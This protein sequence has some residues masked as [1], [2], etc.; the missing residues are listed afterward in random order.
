LDSK[1]ISEQA[2][3]NAI[4]LNTDAGELLAGSA[5]YGEKS[6]DYA[7]GLK[8]QETFAKIAKGTGA[9]VADVAATA[10]IMR[11]QNKNLDEKEMN[12][13]LL[14][15]I[16]Q[17][18]IGSV[19]FSDLG[20]V[21]GNF[22]RSSVSYAGD[23]AKNQGILLG[24][25][26]KFMATAGRDPREA[27]TVTTNLASDTL[28][29]ADAISD[30]VGK[31]V[32][33][34]SGRI[35]M[36][37]QELLA[38][39]MEATG[40][41]L[42]TITNSEKNGGLGYG[43]RSAKAFQAIAPEFNKARDAALSE[44][45]SQKEANKIGADA[46]RADLKPLVEASMTMKE[47][48][49]NVG[50]IMKSSAEQFE[51]ATRELK[52]VIGKDLLPVLRDLLPILKS[53]TPVVGDFLR[54]LTSLVRWAQ[55][56]PFEGAFALL[57][58]SIVKEV[59]VSI[60]QAEIGSLI[61]RLI[62]SS[63]GGAG[64]GIPVPG[65]GG[66][67]GTG[68]GGTGGAPGLGSTLGGAVGVGMAV[69]SV[70]RLMALSDD[71][72]R[73]QSEGGAAGKQAAEDLASGDGNRVAKA[74][75]AIVDANKANTADRQVSSYLDIGQKAV[76]W[77]IMPTIGIANQLGDMAVHG[78]GMKTLADRRNETRR[79]GG[80]LDSPEL[81][82]AVAAPPTAPANADATATAA[83]TENTTATNEQTAVMRDLKKALEEN[84]RAKD[85]SKAGNGG[86]TREPTSF[87]RDGV[88]NPYHPAR[89]GGAPGTPAQ[90]SWPPVR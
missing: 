13:L 58:A 19:E 57:T 62:M 32:L 28:H 59:T 72:S 11:V 26:Q 25:G 47:L 65:V 86:G 34:S 44:G 43:L 71:V 70:D 54:E 84:T 7:G 37:P 53:A 24:L 18:Q 4:K 88:V 39:I 85:N 29:H 50:E 46:I 68:G 60:V 78:L 74:R 67:G 35:Q 36:A 10:G 77:G 55:N 83:T 76:T 16:R 61:K 1:A 75:Q 27:A 90:P 52:M 9:S 17:G 22:T 20:K 30:V 66:G 3:V 12:Q 42:Q 14:N 73:A 87:T 79:A 41:N 56:H 81:R 38:S 6:G 51:G 80:M 63:S 31:K 15:T 23:Q 89:S 69:Y 40:G 48:E 5:K 49:D 21:A 2:R 33:D 45:K 82:K 8:L 64:G